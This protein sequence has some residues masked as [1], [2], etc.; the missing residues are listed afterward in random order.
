MLDD[1]AEHPNKPRSPVSTVS[2]LSHTNA[3][4]P[5]VLHRQRFA[6]RREAGRALAQ[7]LQ[8]LALPAPTVLALPRGGVPVAAEV[9]RVLGAPLDLLM[10]R[11]I[12]APG[13]PELA[14]AAM[15]ALGT[16]VAGSDA[17]Q[18][19][20]PA[21]TFVD[22]GLMAATGADQAHVDKGVAREGAELERRRR[23]YLRGRR[24]MSLD[25]RTVI[26]V[27]DGIATGTTLRAA[28]KA[29]K[30]LKDLGAPVAA[31]QGLQDPG[32]WQGSA[33][34]GPLT[35]V[36]AVPVAPAQVLADLACQVDDTVC[37]W[38]PEPFV[39][40]GV[41]YRDFRQVSDEEVEAALA[42]SP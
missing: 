16:G 27:D 29:L 13:Q 6:N 5:P 15:A 11:K 34:G 31:L 1:G 42:S 7:V 12:G 39:A 9:A 30:A 18:G 33:S 17:E 40:V 28:L 22:P 19:G 8:T 37:L 26:L 4:P 3:V 20:P 41:H 36:L 24:Q 21:Q 25:G 23:R 14:V 35:V 38:T 32:R 2:P 10:V